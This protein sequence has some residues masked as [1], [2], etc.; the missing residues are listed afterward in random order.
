MAERSYKIKA[1]IFDW[2]GTLNDSLWAI[3]KT[4]FICVKKM[5][6]P[7]LSLSKFKK[8][9]ESDYRKFELK[10]GV[11]PDK[12]EMFD[13]LWVEVYKKQK[14][15]LFPG[16]K[17]FLIKIKYGHL[18][19]LVTGG[20]S[21]RLKEELRGYGLNSIFDVIITSEDCYE[22]KPDPEPLIICA[23][24]LDIQP[25]DCLYVGDMNSDI[26]AAK[27]A[28]MISAVVNWG[29]LNDSELHKFSPD[30]I[31]KSLDELEDIIIK[32]R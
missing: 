16:V 17:K 22:K 11:T 8:L 32:N 1:V 27:N 7:E 23:K 21:G 2:D 6:L 12:R 15:K 24:K 29:Y 20:S 4:Y 26:I 14:A 18:L 25:K 28:G 30:I 3:Y 10:I 5:K 9:Y 19:G 31:V 13:K